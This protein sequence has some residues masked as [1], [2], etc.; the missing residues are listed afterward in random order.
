MT[1]LTPSMM[2]LN[3][4]LGR[5]KRAVS[6]ETAPTSYS[7]NNQNW[8]F[9]IGFILDG[10]S[11]YEDLRSSLASEASLFVFANP[12]ITKFTEPN[13]LHWFNP[14]ESYIFISVGH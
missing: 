6:N 13:N 2:S 1:C 8:N 11:K 9:Y 14:S 3:L 12:E 5:K 7:L 4:N 10:Y